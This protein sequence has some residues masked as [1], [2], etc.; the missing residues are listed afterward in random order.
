MIDLPIFD[1]DIFIEEA[2]NFIKE[3][4][5]DS[6][7]NGVVLGLS[8]GIDSTV[9]AC[10]A[11]KAL[12]SQNVKAFILPTSTTSDQDLYDAD[13]MKTMLDIQVEYILLDD[14]YEKFLNLCQREYLPT[15]N[16]K[17]ANM[18]IK[19]RL[20][21]TILYYY[22]SLYNSLVVGTGNKTELYLGYFTKF[23]DGGV[24]LLPIGDLYKEEVNAVAEKLGVP[25]SIIEKAPTAGLSPD[26]T[27]ESEL[28]LSYYYI[29]RIVYLYVEKEYD[30]EK[31]SELLDLQLNDVKHITKLIYNSQHKRLMPP[32]FNKINNKG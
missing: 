2:C 6:H 22:A 31:I 10:L 15:D 5:E 16:E 20:R 25:S 3:K 1:A 29:D 18:N 12:G 24:D 30:A 13:L 32:K 11:V 26:Q 17:L 28:G 14:I 7:T 4:V 23:G 19:P 8:G 27:D 21:M 9:V